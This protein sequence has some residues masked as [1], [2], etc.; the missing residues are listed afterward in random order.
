MIA[1]LAASASQRLLDSMDAEL[2]SDALEGPYWC[3]Y[4]AC[5]IEIR[6]KLIARGLMPC[7][8]S[9]H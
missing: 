6:D 4:F 2:D 1:I 8:R 9:P 7:T 5:Q 3:W